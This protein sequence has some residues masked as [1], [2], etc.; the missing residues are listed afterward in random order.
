MN[1]QSYLSIYAKSFNWAGFFLPKQVYSDCSNLYDFCRTIDNLADEKGYLDTKLKNFN[2]FKQ[3]FKLKNENNQIIKKMWDLINKFKLEERIYRHRCVEAWS[4][5]VPWLGFQMS[6]LLKLC[7]PLS[8]AKYIKFT[9]FYD[10]KIA[11]EQKARWYPWPYTE[12]LTLEEAKNDLSFLV[13]GA[14]GKNLHN[15]FGAPIRL[16]LPWKY[17]FKSIKSIEEI[18]F[19][20][21]RPVSF[22]ENLASNEYGF[23]A[24]VNPA[25]AHPRWSQKTERILGGGERKTEIYNGYGP[26]V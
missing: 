18:E 3:D 26:E 2:T 19:T 7:K 9:T 10:P 5:V 15:Q 16:H 11:T 17:G 8:S 1:E 20:D 12:G 25:V 6:K 4:M 22:W 23:W 14:Y 24:N 21:K 13:F